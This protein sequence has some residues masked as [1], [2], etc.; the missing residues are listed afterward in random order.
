[1]KEVEIGD[2]NGLLSPLNQELL[3]H[4]GPHLLSDGENEFPFLENIPYLRDKPTFRQKAVDHIKDGNYKEALKVLLKDQD[5]FAPIPPPENDALDQILGKNTGFLETMRLLNYG[6]VTEY[7]AHRTTAPTF[8]S[9]LA[10]LQLG[11]SK[12][13]PVTEVACGAGHFLRSLEA[14]GY[15]TTGIDLVFSKLWLARRFMQV[16]GALICA[17]S[18]AKPIFD[19]KSP[20]TV[21]CHDAFYFFKNKKKV[22]E[23][24][25]VLAAGGSVL[26]GHV[27]TTAIDHGV[28][29][30]PISEEK[31]RKMASE[32]AVFYGD[33]ELVD[34]WLNSEEKQAID[35]LISGENP[36]VSWIENPLKNAGLPLDTFA[37][38][39]HLN[40]M[41]SEEN[42]GLTITWPTPGYRKEYE[43]DMPYFDP[44][45]LEK[46]DPNTLKTAS[47]T[48]KM[49]FF[50]QR[51]L[52]DTPAL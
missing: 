41:L 24:L 12:D 6:P 47:N 50:K 4:A 21:L 2:L 34:F 29:G 11:A 37:G 36:V 22:I 9:G 48:E 7:F 49:T 19:S 35:P 5:D 51:I 46:I 52:L 25:R 18:M 28:S 17:D 30:H 23:N 42:N 33:K 3:Q 43:A 8:L 31:Y 45:K 13:V 1:Q 20:N 40:P 14:N 44:K 26:I 38:E 10:L 16:R 32:K 15:Q 27:H 39:L